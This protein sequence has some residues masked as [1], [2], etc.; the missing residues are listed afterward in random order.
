MPDRL[1]N[2]P[3]R[4]TG[5]METHEW[6]DGRTVTFRL[7]LRPYGKRY[8]ISLGT[9]HE[10]W[11]LERARVELEQIMRQIERGT[12]EPPTRREDSASDLDHGE[13]LRVTAYRWWQRR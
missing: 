4:A 13:T 3:R 6:A 5:R 2:M 11:S 8:T 7:K 12:W 9:N 1:A 10:G